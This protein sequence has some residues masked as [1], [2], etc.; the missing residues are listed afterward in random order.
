MY[1]YHF[2]PYEPTAIKRLSCVHAVYEKEVDDFLRA[3]RFIDLHSVFIEALLASVESYSL[4][5]LEKFTRYTRN[6]EL[7][8]ASMARK[9]VEVALELHA[10]KTLPGE[11]IKIVEGYN[12]DDCM[13]TEALHQWLEQQRQELIKSGKEL[14]RPEIKTGGASENIQQLNTRSLA[15]FKALTEKLPE[16]R[17]SWTDE[18]KAKWLLAHLIDYF[19]REDKSAWWEYYRI[20]ELGVASRNGL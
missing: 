1:V 10:F 18:H 3:E 5:E 17:T 19:R 13:A 15:L 12:E 6:I 16:D 20:H 2:A 4:K 9:A 8:S 11:T 14:Q 7:H